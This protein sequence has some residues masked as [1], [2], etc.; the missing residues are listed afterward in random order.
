MFYGDFK[1]EDFSFLQ[2]CLIRFKSIFGT[3]AYGDNNIIIGKT[4]SFLQDSKLKAA[5]ER[6]ATNDQER[7]LIFRLNTLLWAMENA[8]KIEGDIVECGVWKGFLFRVLADYFDFAKIDKTMWLYDTF[9]GIPAKYDTE[10][11]DNP[12]LHEENLFEKVVL[13]FRAYDNIRVIKGQLPDVLKQ[14]APQSISLLHLDLNSSR[15]EIET[16]DVLFDRVSLGGMIVF[17]DYGWS[18]YKPQHDAEKDWA[19][20]RGY[21]ILEMSTGQGL[22]VKR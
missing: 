4:C 7:S 6:H 15:A 10:K 16:L 11:H 14:R 5:I 21:R 2:A 3:V 17:D 18:A 22:L 20:K 13:K 9:A 1:S 12:V 19:D 8:L